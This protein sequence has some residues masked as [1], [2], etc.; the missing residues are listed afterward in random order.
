MRARLDA[1]A[2]KQAER[3][4]QGWRIEFAENE[5]LSWPL[6][7]DGQPFHLTGR[8][9]RIDR[10]ED[11]GRRAIIDYKTSDAGLPPRK[12]HQQ[13]Q[14]WIDLQLP[15]YRYLAQGLA[16]SG[17]F[18]LGYCLFPKDVSKT[19]FVAADWSEEELATADAAAFDVIRGVRSQA[20]WPPADPAP[21]F[22]EEFA[23]ICQDLVFDK[24]R[25]T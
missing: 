21:P 15:L 4:G 12:V 2:D 8:I 19:G 7:V 11:T 9:D 17:P 25:P 5:G 20:F 16:L 24:E 10:H 13:G 6:E 1:F 22:S 14:E 3:A 23:A 18:E